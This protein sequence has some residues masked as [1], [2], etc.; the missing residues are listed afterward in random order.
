MCCAR[1]CLCDVG[2]QSTLTWFYDKSSCHLPAVTPEISNLFGTQ[3][4]AIT[5]K[6]PEAWKTDGTYPKE[7]DVVFYIH[8]ETPDA[9]SPDASFKEHCDRLCELKNKHLIIA[10]TRPNENYQRSGLAS[11][12]EPAYIR[13]KWGVGTYLW[14]LPEVHE[15]IKGMRSS[16]IWMYN[17]RC[18]RKTSNFL[19]SIGIKVVGEF[20]VNHYFSPIKAS[21]IHGTPKP[22]LTWFTLSSAFRIGVQY[23]MRLLLKDFDIYEFEGHTDDHDDLPRNQNV[24]M[25]VDRLP[26]E[27]R[28]EWEGIWMPWIRALLKANNQ[29]IVFIPVR[30]CNT[31]ENLKTLGLHVDLKN[32]HKETVYVAEFEVTRESKWRE[33][34]SRFFGRIAKFLSEYKLQENTLP[35]AMVGFR[36]LNYYYDETATKLSDIPRQQCLEALFCYFESRTSVHPNIPKGFGTVICFH[37]RKGGADEDEKT[38]N[39]TLKNLF[40]NNNEFVIIAT[41]TPGTS[42]NP[43]IGNPLYWVNIRTLWKTAKVLLIRFEYEGSIDGRPG[44]PFVWNA[45]NRQCCTVIRNNLGEVETNDDLEAAKKTS[46][47]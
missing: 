5:Y 32:I 25:L 43:T 47:K 24:V 23:S 42:T 31:K 13:T 40:E 30:G 8:M 4:T 27:D 33:S 2:C 1:C 29:K 10:L 3:A 37:T 28:I 41:V 44:S 14:L 16:Q 38:L 17:D 7:R 20:S 22:T 35:R 46:L 18:I 21:A 26:S 12:T 34:N 19:T 36:A 39:T 45:A 11:M 6:A 15:E 9:K